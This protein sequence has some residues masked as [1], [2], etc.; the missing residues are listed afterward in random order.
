[1]GYTS[2][3]WTPTTENLKVLHDATAKVKASDTKYRRSPLI[4]GGLEIPVE[5]ETQM[6][7]SSENRQALSKYKT[8]IAEN[9][10][11]LM[12]DI[13]WQKASEIRLFSFC[14]VWRANF[15]SSNFTS[16]RV[17]WISFSGWPLSRRCDLKTLIFSSNI[18]LEEFVLRSL[19]TT[20]LMKPCFTPGGWDE[21]KCVYWNVSVGLKCVRT[22]RIEY[23]RNL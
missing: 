23:F 2:R 3:S 6:E 14:F 18:F 22:S 10:H 13:L 12:V 1:M 17:V 20:S 4:Q 19:R 15:L 9:Y 16:K 11:E 7:N 21:V 5:V 8:L